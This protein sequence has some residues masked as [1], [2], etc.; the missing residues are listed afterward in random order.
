[1]GS[2]EPFCRREMLTFT[3]YVEP[4]GFARTTAFLIDILHER[5]RFRLTWRVKA[6]LQLLVENQNL[7]EADKVSVE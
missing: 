7:V 5:C 2:E 6:L 4:R 3:L 1:M